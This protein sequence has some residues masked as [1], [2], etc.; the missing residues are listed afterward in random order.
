VEIALFIAILIVSAVLITLIILQSRTLGMANRD[1]S[2][3]YRTKRGLEK[4]MH[5][6]TIALAA[7]Y[8]LL[9]LITSLPIFS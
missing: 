5:Q 7:V 6:S 8:L 4:T 2:S 1:T 3:I 9:A